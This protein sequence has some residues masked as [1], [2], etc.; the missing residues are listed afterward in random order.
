[1]HFGTVRQAAADLGPFP[2]SALTDTAALLRVEL[3]DGQ[4]TDIAAPGHVFLGKPD[5]GLLTTFMM[6][7]GSVEDL[8]IPLVFYNLIIYF[9]SFVV[10][11]LCSSRKGTQAKTSTAATK[12]KKVS[13]P[14]KPHS[15]RDSCV[16]ALNPGLIFAPASLAGV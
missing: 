15:C 12:Q 11:Y 2:F 1:M 3:L 10:S 5:T 14:M 8:H 6:S 16:P 4:E 9:K 7:L 13:E